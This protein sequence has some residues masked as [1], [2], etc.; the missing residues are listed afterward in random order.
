MP[1]FIEKNYRPTRDKKI[2]WYLWLAHQWICGK[3]LW[4]LKEEPKIP[5]L[6]GENAVLLL[7]LKSFREPGGEEGG[8]R[9][10]RRARGEGRGE[11][12]GRRQQ[13]LPPA[14]PSITYLSLW[15]PDPL[16][17]PLGLF[18]CCSLSYLLRSI[19]SCLSNSTLMGFCTVCLLR[20]ELSFLSVNSHSPTS[21]LTE[22][23]F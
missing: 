2:S 4:G 11:E 20:P 12:K 17:F 14:N 10:R 15:D 8:K 18:W 19:S 13:Q 21:Q 22:N 9:K 6:V 3:D 7:R 1:V 16:T 23:F 5:G